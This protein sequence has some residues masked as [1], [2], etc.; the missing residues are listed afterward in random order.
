MSSGRPPGNLSS[1]AV[2]CGST[3][4]A[5][6]AF[7]AAAVSLGRLFAER[8]IRL[9]YGGGHVGLMG[10]IADAVLADGGE[11]LG[12]IT[13]A[14]KAKEVAHR[15]LTELVVTET[16]HERKAAMA[17][18][19]DAFIMLPG[20]YGTFDEFFEALTWT[21]LGIHDKPCGVLDVAGF[22][23]P[24]RDLLDAGTTAGFV[25]PVHRN[26]VITESEPAALLDRLEVWTPVRVGK[27]L[28]K[29]E[30]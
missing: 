21:Q 15:Q 25:L 20:G 9:V 27:W 11:V 14:L 13:R 7:A 8:G 16:M 24:L 30:R 23:A 29:S 19:A 22:F 26:L 3:R 17:D 12:V 18:A 4:G 6:P 5:D 10:V 28:D 1:I 2:Y